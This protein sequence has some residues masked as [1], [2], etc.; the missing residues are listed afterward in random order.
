VAA[1]NFGIVTSFEFRLHPLE[2]VLARPVLH[3]LEAARGPLS[4]YRQLATS[5]RGELT[6]QATFVPAPDGSGA[7][8]CDVGACHAAT[9][10]PPKPACG[11]CASTEPRQQTSPSGCPTRW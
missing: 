2:T 8:M 9:P 10:A 5:T 4:A 6:T 7:K 3:P 11:H 1:G